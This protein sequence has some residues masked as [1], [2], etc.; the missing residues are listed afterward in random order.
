MRG[1]IYRVVNR[2]GIQDYHTLAEAKAKAKPI[3]HIQFVANGGYAVVSSVKRIYATPA[4]VKKCMRRIG[5][6]E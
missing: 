5:F 6:E 4:W 2:Y 1:I 3:D